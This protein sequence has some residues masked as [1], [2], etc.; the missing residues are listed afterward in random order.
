MFSQ[1]FVDEA[2]CDVFRFLWYPDN[3]LSREPVDYR[4]RTHVLE[5]KSSPCCTAYALRATAHDNLTKASETTVRT[6]FRN[7]YVDDV[8]CS[9]KSADSAIDLT[10]QLS[11]LLNSGG[12]HLTKF[13][14]NNQK[15]LSSIPQKDLAES[16]DLDRDCLPAQRALGVYRNA[17][18]DRLMV[19]VDVKRRPCTRRD[20]L[21][22]T[23]DPLGLIQPFILP[24]KQLLQEACKRSLR[25]DDDLSNLPGL[26]MH[27][28]KWLL[29]LP[30]LEKVS[31]KRSLTLPEKEIAGLELHT[32]SD[33]SISGYGVDVYVRVRYVDGVV[34]CCFLLGKARVAPIKF[35][36]VPHLEL[37]AAVLASKVTNFVI[38]ELDIKFS[39]VFL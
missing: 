34:K 1:V 20:L 24:A 25:W 29:A 4:M 22:Q 12:F 2:D 30:Q 5:A 39:K 7:V 16:V 36:R 37:T 33:A 27:W 17:S 14:S 6:V 19:K 23:Y 28:E 11:K 21:S 8:C 32:F 38:N 35:V 3:D 31:I 15:V 13:L 26:G 9:C 18:S 10:V